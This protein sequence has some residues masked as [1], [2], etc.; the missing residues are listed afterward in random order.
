[1]FFRHGFFAVKI[2]TN[3]VR[4]ST[5]PRTNEVPKVCL[6]LCTGSFQTTVLVKWKNLKQRVSGIASWLQCHSNADQTTVFRGSNL[7]TEASTARKKS[8]TFSLLCHVNLLQYLLYYDIWYQI[9][10][11]SILI[12]IY[13][14]LI[15]LYCTLYK[16]ITP[17]WSA[18][19]TTIYY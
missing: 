9:I 13:T 17:Y 5:A 8:A 15:R 14:I 19:Y 1:M 4:P 7:T 11:N 3:P 12:Y 16:N 2:Y 18:L 10:L 6:F